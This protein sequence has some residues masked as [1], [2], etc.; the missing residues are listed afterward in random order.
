MIF[1]H[2]F[3]FNHAVVVSVLLFAAS[4][5]IIYGCRRNHERALTNPASPGPIFLNV[6]KGVSP[7]QMKVNGLT[8]MVTDQASGAVVASQAFT[9][10]T[11]PLNLAFNVIIPPCLYTITARVVLTDGSTNADS[12]NVNACTYAD[13]AITLIIVTEIPTPTPSPTP[14]STETPRPMPT[15]I[16]TEVPTPTPVLPTATPTVTPTPNPCIVTTTADSGTGSLRQALATSP[17]CTTITFTSAVSTI[18]LG[19]AP[20]NV[21]GSCT[22]LIIDG[23]GGSG[24]QVILNGNNA[25]TVLSVSGVATLNA[26]TISGGWNPGLGGGIFVNSSGSVTLTSSTIVTANAAELGGG[27]ANSGTINVGGTISANTANGF[28]GGIANFGALMLS[29]GH[30][31]AGNHSDN[32][33]D[34]GTFENGGGIYT[35]GSCPT[36]ANYGSGNYRGNPGVLDNCNGNP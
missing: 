15:E 6:A 32:N 8:V 27:I 16:P 13:G 26:L 31:I 2:T 5:T 20:L 23:S 28:G 10:P 21:P 19:G 34:G 3:R 17:C 1:K 36:G 29:A 7:A 12:A 9:E 22:N 11:L 24:N 18:I 35:A 25:S 30:L 4:S 14:T 33:N